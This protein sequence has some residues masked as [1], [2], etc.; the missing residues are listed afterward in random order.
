VANRR[1]TRLP[2]DRPRRKRAKDASSAPAASFSASHRRPQARDGRTSCA[3]ATSATATGC[4]LHRVPEIDVQGAV[5]RELGRRRLPDSP[6]P[7][8][9]AAQVAREHRQRASPGTK[10]WVRGGSRTRTT[11]ALSDGHRGE[12]VLDEL[13]PEHGGLPAQTAGPARRRPPRAAHPDY[14]GLNLTA[15]GAQSLLTH[16]TKASSGPRRFDPRE[17]SLPEAQVR[18]PRDSTASRPRRLRR[19]GSAGMF[20]DS[21]AD[22][23]GIRPLAQREGTRPK[24]PIPAHL[25]STRTKQLRLKRVRERGHQAVHQRPHPRFRRSAYPRPRRAHRRG[26][27]RAAAHAVAHSED[28]RKDVQ[29]LHAS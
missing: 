21:D 3:P 28:L 12:L 2:S 20:I 19:A 24:P 29:E 10:P 16:E 6:V 25:E 9:E 5:N 11:S 7:Q 17:A 8:L 15:R 1:S 4:P 27:A 13:L 26:R 23:S 22:S 18:R 14:R